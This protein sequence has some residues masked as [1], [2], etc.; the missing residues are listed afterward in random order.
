LNSIVSGVTA[1]FTK[2]AV[3]LALLCMDGR[4]WEKMHVMLLYRYEGGCRM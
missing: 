4:R 2:H 3:I 1:F